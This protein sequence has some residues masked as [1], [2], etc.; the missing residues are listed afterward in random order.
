LLKAA[1]LPLRRQED[2]VG[3]WGCR[4]SL[5][6]S[7]ILVGLLWGHGGGDV[8]ALWAALLAWA[9]CVAFF[10]V[11][12][13]VIAESGFAFLQTPS[14]IHEFSVGMGLPLG[15]PLAPFIA[16]NLIGQSLLSDTRENVSGFLVQSTALT[17]QCRGSFPRLFAVIAALVVVA[18]LA[19][20]VSS[21]VAAWSLTAGV[22]SG[23]PS[24]A[25]DFVTRSNMDSFRPVLFGLL[26]MQQ[27][28]ILVGFLLIFAVVGLRRLWPRSPLHPIGL[29]LA[30][31]WPVFEMWSSL[32][33]GWLI[34]VLVLRYGGVLLY[35]RLKPV[36]VGI[37][38]GDCL[39]YGL[40]V[41]CKAI[42]VAHGWKWT[43]CPLWLG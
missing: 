3:V 26:D 42:Y 38:V 39:G 1:V 12:A 25:S 23:A 29:I 2:Q 35:R 28:S 6:A 9:L 37:I 19:G 20:G 14:T 40:Q 21:L 31:A 10:V 15:L 16:L 27:M 8:P 22:S 7:V 30:G 36:A 33:L 32:M 24:S 18:A 43:D 34:K 41:L 13:R 17:Q 4:I 5:A 11:I